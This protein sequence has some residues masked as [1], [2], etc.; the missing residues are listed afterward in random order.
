MKKLFVAILILS[1]IVTAFSGCSSGSDYT[2]ALKLIEDEKYEEAYELLNEA[3]RGTEDLN[4][5]RALL[6]RFQVVYK[7]TETTAYK[8][9]HADKYNPQTV[10]IYTTVELDD[11][12]NV[13]LEEV[14]DKDTVLS[15]YTYSYEYDNNDNVTTKLAYDLNGN[16]TR[17][18]TFEY[19]KHG[20]IQLVAYYS[21]DGETSSQMKYEHKFDDNGHVTDV[22]V[23]NEKDEFQSHTKKE[24]D[25]Y[26]NATLSATLNYLGEIIT[27]TTYEY[28]ENGNLLLETDY[29]TD[30][31][32]GNTEYQYD[33]NGNLTSTTKYGNNKN[34]GQSKFE[35]KYD[36]S[37]Y[38]ISISELPYNYNGYDTVGTKTVME[39]DENGF[40]CK[41]LI[42]S[43]S[44]LKEEITFS[45]P[46]VLY[47]PFPD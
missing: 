33:E 43:D 20:L 38:L 36:E 5:C 46:M 34:A 37:G 15:K 21:S 12:G 19:D 16:L 6:K 25:K 23:Y 22:I 27:K 41:K 10:E 30:E 29:I 28:D 17:K 35:Y 7:R 32:N 18:Q 26:G 47:T 8:V 11:M 39:Y 1:F 3:V 40:I 31:Y 24:Y 9:S 44:R 4:E 2:R 42:Y 13:I 14:R 45:D